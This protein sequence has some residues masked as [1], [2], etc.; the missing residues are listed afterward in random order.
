MGPM[1]S[2]LPEM[3]ITPNDRRV[4]RLRRWREIRDA[5]D[6]ALVAGMASGDERAAAA[7]VERH[8]GR[9]FGV[10]FA[11]TSN[12]A[13]AQDVAQEAFLRAW[14][15]A[16]VFDPRRAPA[17]SWLSTITR[18]LAIDALRLQRA[19]PVDPDDAV[20]LGI[21]STATPPEAHAE[22]VEAIDR[23]RAALRTIPVDQRRALVRSAFYGQSATEIAD[24]EAIPL[25][26]AKSRIR[27]G[28]SKVRDLLDGEEE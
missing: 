22:H 20:W 9:V 4:R 3:E 11:I 10:A 14:R 17:T 16:A 25:G 26:T 27:L 2:C 21:D 28:L 12:R 6:E 19:I 5:S 8:Q 7:F 13:T 18:N 23:V 15:H 1:A 24:A